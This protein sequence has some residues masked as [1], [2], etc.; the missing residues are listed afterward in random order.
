M[1]KGLTII[2][3]LALVASL[4]GC[5]STRGYFVDRGRDAADIFTV[6]AGVGGGGQVRLGPIPLG[7]LRTSDV[8][9]LRYG[10]V[11][12]RAHPPDTE[13]EEKCRTCG[14]I[15]GILLFPVCCL[16]GFG[17]DGKGVSRYFEAIGNALDYYDKFPMSEPQLL[18]HKDA[19]GVR[20][21]DSYQLEAVAGLGLVFRVGIN[22]GELLDFILGWTTIDIFGDDLEARRR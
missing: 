4:T 2:C 3:L 19:Q 10:D 5:A 17:G 15:C 22:F 13:A 20:A 11:F 18:R 8:T 14:A 21:S 9:G 16:V 6:T 1:N 12:C 7:F